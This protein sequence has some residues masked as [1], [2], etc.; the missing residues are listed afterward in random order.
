M[1]HYSFIVSA[2]LGAY[3]FKDIMMYRDDL[4]Y[5]GM[6]WDNLSCALSNWA[7]HNALTIYI[8]KREQCLKK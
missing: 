3:T 2:Q 6:R 1:H 5:S 8:A 4:F 7:L